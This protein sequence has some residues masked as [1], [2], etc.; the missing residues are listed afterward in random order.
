MGDDGISPPVRPGT[1]LAPG[2][3]PACWMRRHARLLEWVD[4]PRRSSMWLAGVTALPMPLARASTPWETL[5]GILG[6]R[7]WGGRGEQDAGK[8]RPR[9]SVSS[10]PAP[11]RA[12]RVRGAGS[13]Q[14]PQRGSATRGNVSPGR[15][16]RSTAWF[17]GTRAASVE[18][19]ESHPGSRADAGTASAGGRRTPSIVQSRV[20]RRHLQA[21]AGE[22]VSDLSTS[23]RATRAGGGAM[24][25]PPTSRARLASLRGTGRVEGA[26]AE[27][28]TDRV[29]DA[30]RA[31]AWLAR[32]AR[33]SVGKV[34]RRGGPLAA[35]STIAAEALER[36][37]RRTLEGPRVSGAVS[38]FLRPPSRRPG[39]EH[40]ARGAGASRAAGSV[41]ARPDGE[42]S[43]RPAPAGAAPART[44]GTGGRGA[45]GTAGE[46][47]RALRPGPAVTPGHGPQ[48]APRADGGEPLLQRLL[49]DAGAALSHGDTERSTFRTLDSLPGDPGRAP[50]QAEPDARQREEPSRSQREETLRPH[51]EETVR[52]HGATATP[53]SEPSMDGPREPAPL[54][55]SVDELQERLKRILDDEAR[56]HGINV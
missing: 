17:A 12:S 20:S 6:T 30:A 46:Q 1:H 24:P 39:T 52:S 16:R 37:A 33:R 32:V 4:F 49:R 38:S 10:L 21:L 19:D 11:E 14:R 50:L 29:A 53:A 44:V 23:S 25:S 13:G 22:R 45:V 9:G 26:G 35:R 51:R 47:A 15:G 3:T 28:V 55:D 40:A 18:Y 2:Y 41:T 7:D 27:G 54:P 36:Q 31:G 48:R 8:A 42:E 56:R 43:A 5:A 34:P